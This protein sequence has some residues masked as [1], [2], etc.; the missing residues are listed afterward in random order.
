MLDLVHSGAYHAWISGQWS[1][2]TWLAC[3]NP[4]TAILF[5]GVPHTPSGLSVEVIGPASW[6]LHWRPEIYGTWL[7]QILIHQNGAGWIAPVDGPSSAF[8]EF[9]PWTFI[10]YGGQAYNASKASFLEGRADFILPPG[11]AYAFYLNFVAWDAT[12]QGPFAF[13]TTW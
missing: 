4:A 1:G 2:G 13:E 9:S 11:G 3:P 5:N 10:D 8:P 6:R 7:V 12:T